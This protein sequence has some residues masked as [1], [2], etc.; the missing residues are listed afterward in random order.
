MSQSK[1]LKCKVR[2]PPH[3]FSDSEHLSY[4]L[5]AI[6]FTLNY[7]KTPHKP[8]GLNPQNSN[9]KAKSLGIPTPR[10]KPDGSSLHTL[11]ATK[12]EWGVE[13]IPSR[14]TST[15]RIRILLQ[16]YS[17]ESKDLTKPYT[18]LAFDILAR[19]LEKD[20]DHLL[21]AMRCHFIP[22]GCFGGDGELW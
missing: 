21:G 3:S 15:R 12:K 22:S 16:F 8:V 10:T 19:S 5:Y 7:K 20:G 13:D 1:H 18:A 14:N 2:C 17:M 4:N 9:L 11:P 6:R